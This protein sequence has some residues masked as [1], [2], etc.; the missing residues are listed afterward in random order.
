MRL[1]ELYSKVNGNT[2]IEVYTGV[3]EFIAE[4]NDKESIPDFLNEQTVSAI[5]PHEN[6]IEVILDEDYIT[7]IICGALEALL[8]DRLNDLE[9][10]ENVGNVLLNIEEFIDEINDFRQDL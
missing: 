10:G 3:N 1:E 9:N 5:V 7:D 2:T 8:R 4:S 6:K